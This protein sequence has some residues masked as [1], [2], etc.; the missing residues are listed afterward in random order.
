MWAKDANDNGTMLWENAINYV[1]DLNLGS[2]SCGSSYTDW[3]LPNIKELQSLIDFKNYDPSLPSDHPFLKFGKI[4][5]VEYI[6]LIQLWLLRVAH[7]NA[8]WWRDRQH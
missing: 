2:D 1:N 7:L 6:A 3:R 5:L 4:L 8:G